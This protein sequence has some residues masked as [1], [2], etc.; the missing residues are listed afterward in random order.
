MLIHNNNSYTL[1]S[2]CN[3]EIKKKKQP[4]I[5]ARSWRKEEAERKGYVRKKRHMQGRSIGVK[6]I[7]KRFPRRFQMNFTGF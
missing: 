4:G 1:L 6:F 7:R 2:I 5:T 3:Q